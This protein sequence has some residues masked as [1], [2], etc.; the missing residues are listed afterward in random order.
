MVLKPEI[1]VGLAPLTLGVSVARTCPAD[2]GGSTGEVAAVDDSESGWLDGGRGGVKLLM[3]RWDSGRCV[4]AIMNYTLVR[5]LWRD[6]RKQPRTRWSELSNER[7][8]GAY[9]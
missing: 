1:A 5:V 6:G 7:T 8:K 4:E 9:G 2:G 3:L